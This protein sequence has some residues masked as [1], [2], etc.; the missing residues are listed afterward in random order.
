LSFLKAILTRLSLS[1]ERLAL[2][3]VNQYI[4][5][6]GGDP[7]K[8]TLWGESAGAMSVGMHLVHNGGNQEGL[9]R[10]A[11]MVRE[12]NYAIHHKH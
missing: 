2:K 4:A 3:W 10:A 12:A 6:F 5:A 9:F 1:L 11:F 7:T 8:V